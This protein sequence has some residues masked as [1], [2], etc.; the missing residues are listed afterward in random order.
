MVTDLVSLLIYLSSGAASV[1]ISKLLEKFEWFQAQSPNGKLF[2][3]FGA[4]AVVAVLAVFM[5]G[6]IV[7]HPFVSDLID[8]YVKALLPVFN[9]LIAQMTHGMAKVQA[10]RARAV[11]RSIRGE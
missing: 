11:G 10:F 7:Q 1:G 2:S 9:M 6:V 3:V 8:P 5:Q 4:S